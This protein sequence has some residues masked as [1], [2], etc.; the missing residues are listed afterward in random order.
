MVLVR[1]LAAGAPVM[2]SFTLAPG[3]SMAGVVIVTTP[4]R[5]A[6]GLPAAGL[7]ASSADGGVCWE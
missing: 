5:V 3:R 4:R 6:A 2:P 7:L 1:R